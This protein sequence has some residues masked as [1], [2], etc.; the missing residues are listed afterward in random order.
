MQ[1]HYNM[2]LRN[3]MCTSGEAVPIPPPSLPSGMV[4]HKQQ[5]GL[6]EADYMVEIAPMRSATFERVPYFA[7]IFFTTCP[8]GT[9]PLGTSWAGTGTSRR[10]K[11]SA[12]SRLGCA[13]R[14]SLEDPFGHDEM[15]RR[16]LLW[17]QNVYCRATRD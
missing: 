2:A 14:P 9:C 13:L 12:P 8:L 6:V 3:C 10:A 11:L 5:C 16:Q 1:Q 17:L 7:P 15:I 4:A